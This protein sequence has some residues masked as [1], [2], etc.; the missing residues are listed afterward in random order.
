MDRSQRDLLFVAVITENII[1]FKIF[2]ND[3]NLRDKDKTVIMKVIKK[4]NN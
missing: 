1:F 4:R 2:Q 3:F